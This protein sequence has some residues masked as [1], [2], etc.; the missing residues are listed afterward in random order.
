MELITGSAF[1]LITGLPIFQVMIYNYKTSKIPETHPIK[2][3]QH[4]V[5]CLKWGVN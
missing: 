2:Q 4:F 3:K 1:Q 5:A